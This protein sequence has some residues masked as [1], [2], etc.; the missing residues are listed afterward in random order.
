MNKPVTIQCDA[1]D[2]A[3]GATLLQ[4]GKP[5]AFASTT[6]TAAQQRYA[7]IEK[8]TLAICFATRKFR[9]YI[10]GK[11]E[12]IVETDH[13]P[14]E[15]IFS[16]SLLAAPIRL[17]RMLLQLQ[18]YNLIVKYK[19]GSEQ[20]IADLLSRATPPHSQSDIVMKSYD[21]F[22]TQLEEINATEYTNISD[23]QIQKIRKETEKDPNLQSLKDTVLK[24]WPDSKE[25]CSP[26]VLDYWTYRDE[27][28]L[29]NG[30]LYKGLRIIIP[31]AMQND[32]LQRIHSSHLGTEACIRKANVS[33]FWPGIR[34]EIKNTVNSCIACAEI[35]NTQQKEPLQTTE[36]PNRAW[37]KIAV[38]EF[39][40]KGRNYL[41]TVDYYS[42]YFEVD[43]LHSSTS[44]SIIKALQIHFARMGI[45]DI[46]VTDNNANLVSEEFSK[47]ARKWQFQ[48]VTSSPHFPR[49]NGKVESAVKII[50]N[51]MQKCTKSGENIYKALLDWRNTP[52]AQMSSSPIQRLISRR[53]KTT[54][55]I[56]EKLL[57]PEIQNNVKEKL[58]VKR[59][60]SKYY[61]D[62]TAKSLPQLQIGQ[63]IYVK[64]YNKDSE[65]WKPGLIT[66]K[67]S[68]RSYIINTQ[69]Q[70][71]RRNRIHLKP[72]S[73]NHE[74]TPDNPVEIDYDPITSN[75]HACEKQQ[76]TSEKPS[77]PQPLLRRSSRPRKQTTPYVHIP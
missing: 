77:S 76:E 27:I 5:I 21:I 11:E 49:S 7:V 6:M 53:T 12:V 42:D 17:Q 8:E 68:D 58:E 66:N 71:M 60:H 9:D 2:K 62:R 50:K 57:Q 32:M 38:D 10:L 35:N 74:N 70:T 15:S 22:C 33:I 24:G 39:H 47:F 25:M 26:M 13:K 43:R 67:L 61:H 16:K 28:T 72:R 59:Q 3:L 73:N 69:G 65:P 51:M 37:S 75:N 19:K 23:T 34:S 36:L 1:S 14:L 4:D 30:I 44:Q 64:P 63:P 45:P 29:Q 54:L 41:I 56:N 31:K 55:P 18:R 52:T 48:H 40:F 46:V 20:Y